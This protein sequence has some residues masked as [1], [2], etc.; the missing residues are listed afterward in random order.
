MILF[1][2]V[3]SLLYESMYFASDSVRASGSPAMSNSL[4]NDLSSV[5]LNL[6]LNWLNVSGVKANT[7]EP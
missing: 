4:M 5:S 7:L 3:S 1:L 6:L 2:R